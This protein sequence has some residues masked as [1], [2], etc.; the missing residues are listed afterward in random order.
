MTVRLNLHGRNIV[1][2]LDNDILNEAWRGSRPGESGGIHSD[3]CAHSVQRI[4]QRSR[5]AYNLRWRAQY[6]SQKAQ[7]ANSSSIR[8]ARKQEPVRGNRA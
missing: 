2:R 1:L 3:V 6:I 7:C 5:Q 4:K 8:R